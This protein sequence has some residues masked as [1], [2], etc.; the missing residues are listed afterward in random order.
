MNRYR[1]NRTRN[2]IYKARKL[3]NVLLGHGS[4]LQE[5]TSLLTPVHS[6]PP[7]RGG[8]LVQVRDRLCVPP[9]HVTLHSCQ[10]SQAVQFPSTVKEHND[11]VISGH[12]RP[13]V[14]STNKC[15]YSKR[16]AFSNRLT[17]HELKMKMNWLNG[18]TCKV[19]TNDQ[20]AQLTPNDHPKSES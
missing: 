5:R 19:A 17:N 11:N 16:A 4:S 1:R 10:S 9:P 7:Y 18:M 15:R 20:E 3:E 14:N 6:W 8:G 13:H 12:Y 2:L